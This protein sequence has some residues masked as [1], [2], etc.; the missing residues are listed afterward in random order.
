MLSPCAPTS[1]CSFHFLPSISDCSKF[2]IDAVVFLLA[3]DVLQIPDKL[4]IM[5]DKLKAVDITG[6]LL[7]HHPRIDRNAIPF[8]HIDIKLELAPGGEKSIFNLFEFLIGAGEDQ[9]LF[10]SQIPSECLCDVVFNC[11]PS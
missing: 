4:S 8:D 7:V 6:N 3:T 9:I 10:I 2:V 1:S 5:A 11:R